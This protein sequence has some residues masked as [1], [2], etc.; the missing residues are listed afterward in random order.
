MRKKVLCRVLIGLLWVLA[1]TA[2]AFAQ[3]KTISGIISDQNGVP[4]EKATIKAKGGQ[5]YAT[6]DANGQFR[7]AIPQN[8][9]VLEISYVGMKPMDVS[10]EGKQS[11]LVTLNVTESKLNEVVVIGYGTA[12]RSD[13]STA[14]SSIKAK[15]LKD[16]PVAG[17]DQALQ[18]KVAGVSIT[19]NSGQPGGGVSIRVRGITSV[20]GNEPL[21]VIDGVPILS[22]TKSIAHDQLGGK[23]G[24][25]DQSVMA[26]LNP[27]DIASIDILKDAS[28][29]AIYG[30]L[31]ANG[32]VLITTKRGKSGEGRLTYDVYHGW[33]SVPK[34]L[35]VMNLR[36]YAEYYNSLVPEIRAAGNSVDTIGE[37]KDP[38]LLGN[39]TNWQKELFQTGQIDNHQLA[40]SGGQAKTTYYFSLNYFNQTGTIIGSK[41]NRYASR[42]SIDQQ[43][44]SWLKAGISANL[45]RSNQRITLTDGVETPT[46]IV[47]YNSPATPVK[48]SDG[49]YITSANF[50]GTSLGNAN[51][52]PIATALLRDVRAVQSKGYGNIY[53]DLQFSKYLSLRNEVNF[54]YQLNENSAFQPYY[55]N[56]ATGQAVMA[57]S[58]LREDRNTNFYW[59]LRNYLTYNQSFGK[60][61]V[62]AVVG[63]EAQAS[64]WDNKWITV[65]NLE[66]NLQST[67]AGTVVPAQTSG[68]KGDWSMESYFARATYTYDNRYSISGSIRRDG[69]SSFGP[70]NRIGYFSAGSAGWTVTNEKFAR[71]WKFIDYLKLRV[72]AGSVGNQNSPI[73]NAY[74]TNIR[75]FTVAPFGPGGVPANV[76]NPD[77][78]WES[79]TT[80]NGGVDLSFLKKRVELSVDVYKKITTNMILSI[81]PPMFLGLDPNPPK[82]DYKEIEPAVTNAG[83]MTN[84]GVDISLTT[85]NIQ[86]NDFSWKTSIVFSRY[87]NLLVRLNSP[88]ALLK[89]A[90]QDFTQDGS[91]VNIT[92]AGRAV[93]SFYGYVTD[94]LFRDM[95]ELNNGT[96]WGLAVGPQGVY[97][98]DIRYKDISGPDGKPDNKIGSEDVTFIG[99]PNPSF[100]YGI[101]NSFTFKGFD[102]SFFLQG[103]QG[104]R[105]FN[106]T[107]KYTEGMTSIYLNQST[108]VISRY[109]TANPQA[110]IPRYNQWNNNNTRNSD[111]YI[112]NGSYLRVQNISLGYNFPARW[113]SKA[114][115]ANARLYLSAQ[116]VYTFTKYTGY[117]PEIGSFDKNVLSQ[118]VDNGHYPNPRTITI[119]ANIEF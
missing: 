78:S 76:G 113:I 28:A 74:S 21:Y 42:F 77:L 12:R 110:S 6:S 98:G 85:Y 86:R 80:Y 99:D 84:T 62:N 93:G 96:D 18:G 48:G 88:T 89:G 114:K 44:K 41:F 95:N 8:T 87:K 66:Q 23:A 20:N 102:F 118:N 43:V 10:I 35:P 119:G 55:L 64:H 67:S 46:A 97:L 52:N 27:A 73:Q 25:V 70:N 115:M 50:G 69:A 91:V 54:D 45:S 4:L 68:K 101:T 72:G 26:T 103:V 111:R 19:N 22:N 51:G 38:S 100:T 3:T 107:R 112:E 36:Q 94:G 75:L 24:Q 33:Q 1:Q 92:Q 117:D 83:E 116:N 81:V 58:K 53:A 11:V 16:L 108:D 109:T 60:H 105:I 39:G 49:K 65:T 37:L 71:D 30:S 47:L 56:E 17:I 31:A 106:W 90:E 40:F 13:V 14:V 9:S 63:H 61:A 34:L 5:R 29:Q 82:N 32:V 57:P 59:G 2:P 79:V 7:L 104:T 15:D